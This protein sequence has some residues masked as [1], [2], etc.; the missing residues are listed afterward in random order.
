MDVTKLCTDIDNKI[1]VISEN[2]IIFKAKLIQD[3]NILFA[4]DNLSYS[5]IDYSACM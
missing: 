5:E 1:Y 4:K 2:I 3:Y